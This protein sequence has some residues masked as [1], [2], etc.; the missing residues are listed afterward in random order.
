ME[1]VSHAPQRTGVKSDADIMKLMKLM[2]LMKRAAAG[3]R[4]VACGLVRDDPLRLPRLARSPVA[5][6]G[7]CDDMPVE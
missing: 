2:K 6:V 5:S 3:R 1:R 4:S 7:T